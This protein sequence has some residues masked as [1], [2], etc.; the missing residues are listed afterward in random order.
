MNITYSLSKVGI[1]NRSSFL[2]NTICPA[3]VTAPPTVITIS[4]LEFTET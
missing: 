2:E 3:G 1:D 4:L